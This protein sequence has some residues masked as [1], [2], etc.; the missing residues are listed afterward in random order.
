MTAI[1]TK[2]KQRIQDTRKAKQK[3]KM[4]RIAAAAAAGS[5]TAML[6]YGKAGACSTEY[7][8]KKN[9]TLFSLAQ[10]YN[11]TVEQLMEANGLTSDK[12]MAGQQ[13]LV[14]DKVSMES[15][16]HIVQKGDTLY[17]LAK[18]HGV[19]VKE[20]KEQ[21]SLKSDQINIGQTIK[22]A[23]AE[24]QE[25][26]LYTVVPGDTLWG[27]SHRFGVK[28]EQVTK[29]NGLKKEMVLI[30]QNLV[31]PGKSEVTEAEVIGAADKFTVEFKYHGEPFV[32]K[33]PYGTASDFQNMSGHIVHVIHKNGALISVF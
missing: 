7:T 3:Q 1:T 13:L 20:L 15:G 30:G 6:I 10:K 19:T 31:I 18:K 26:E 23:A 29:A 16:I 14:P 33:V 4:K 21:N 9:D 28:P 27:I 24:Q 22:L 2:R 5:I 25:G 12:I 32:L 8:V 11:V 17:S